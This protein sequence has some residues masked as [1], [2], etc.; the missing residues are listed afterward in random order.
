[1][2]FNEW[3]FLT[4][5]MSGDE[6]V[7][8]INGVEQASGTLSEGDFSGV[9]ASEIFYLGSAGLVAGFDDFKVFTR[10]LVFE[11]VKALY[12]SY[13]E[14]ETKYTYGGKELDDNTNLYYFN[15]RYYD[16]TI[17]RFINVDPIQDGSNWYVYVNNNPLNMVDPTG[18]MQMEVDPTGLM[19]MENGASSG[20]YMPSIIPGG[21][22]NYISNMMTAATRWQ[23]GDVIGTKTH[24][25][26]GTEF[27]NIVEELDH[28][29]QFTSVIAIGATTTFANYLLGGVAALA[30]AP[31]AIA[32]LAMGDGMQ[33]S[34]LRAASTVSVMEVMI[35]SLEEDFGYELADLNV[36]ISNEIVALDAEQAEEVGTGIVHQMRL[37]VTDPTGKDTL[38]DQV[39]YSQPQVLNEVEKQQPGTETGGGS[40]NY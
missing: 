36:T 11:H 17:G 2:N 7:I 38:V 16:A 30:L 22:S 27:Q 20:W 24:N 35:D 14:D 19:Q 34:N 37:T 13:L 28:S 39:F 29:H 18:L 40:H 25:M 23:G 3:Y 8:Y 1:M 33:T 6:K 26:N 9:P 21:L 4:F 12:D 10:A 32:D 15:A 31:W 5:T